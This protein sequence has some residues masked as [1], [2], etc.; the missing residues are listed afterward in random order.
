[1]AAQ[2][3]KDLEK[4]PGSPSHLHPVEMRPQ[5][6]TDIKDKGKEDCALYGDKNIYTPTIMGRAAPLSRLHI[7]FVAVMQIWMSLS[8]LGLERAAFDQLPGWVSYVSSTSIEKWCKE[9]AH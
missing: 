5:I 1:M 7:S 8:F 4:Q 6:G 2:N 3:L 9:I